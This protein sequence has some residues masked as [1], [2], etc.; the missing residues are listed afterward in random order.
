MEKMKLPE[1]DM[2]EEA[3]WRGGTKT[4]NEFHKDN[5]KA[6][7]YNNAEM[8]SWGY[9]VGRQGKNANSVDE[10]VLGHDH[11]HIGHADGIKQ[12]RAKGPLKEAHPTQVIP[13]HP[14][15]VAGIEGSSAA[16]AKYGIKIGRDSAKEAFKK[17]MFERL[18]QKEANARDRFSDISN[19]AGLDH[20]TN[21]I[22]QNLH[23]LIHQADQA[24]EVYGKDSIEYDTL[25]GRLSNQIAAYGR[26]GNFTLEELQHYDTKHAQSMRDARQMLAEVTGV[27]LE[28]HVNYSWTNVT[29]NLGNAAGDF[30]S[31]VPSR[32]GRSGYSRIDWPARPET[33]LN[34]HYGGKELYTNVSQQASDTYKKPN[35]IQKLQ[36]FLAKKKLNR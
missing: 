5:P 29:A 8:Y 4:F 35:P 13:Q 28:G 23:F 11:Y 31:E 32:L 22:Q 1:E 7:H 19:P 36:D 2:R 12:F 6:I 21:F 20:G 26:G 33:P 24:R 14:V 10:E 3:A 34:R 30:A 17:G 15:A 16:E 18:L 27:P 25:I 9:S